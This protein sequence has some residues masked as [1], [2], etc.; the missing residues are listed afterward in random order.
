MTSL[1]TLY[2]L[3]GHHGGPQYSP[4]VF[5]AMLSLYHKQ[6]QFEVKELV[7]TELRAKKE[8]WKTDRPTL[9]A[10][11]LANGTVIGDSDKIAEWLDE[12]YP[13][14]PSLFVPD[15]PSSEVSPG[16]LQLAKNY[17]KYINST[18]GSPALLGTPFSPF[19][20][21]IANG[22]LGLIKADKDRVY[23]TSDTKLGVQDGWS[24]LQK[25]DRDQSIRQAKTFVKPL[26]SLLKSSKFL[27]GENPGIVDYT[28]W[29]RYAFQRVADPSGAKQIWRS[30]A[31]P[32]V[33]KW[34]DSI[35]ERYSE[36]LKDQKSRWPADAN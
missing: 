14:K 27:N 33:A 29:G 26:E 32:T 19:F 28:L 23:F 5:K 7:W 31:T 17:F 11:E 6:V 16:S 9:P 1:P 36:Q 10:L 34:I 15:V 24:K 35:E 21:S 2:V 3:V 12:Q 18:F 4:T 8:A 30:E 22:I 13:D 20:S 25:L